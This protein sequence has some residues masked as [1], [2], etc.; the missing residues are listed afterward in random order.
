VCDHRIV[1]ATKP[2]KFWLRVDVRRD[3]EATFTNFKLLPQTKFSYEA[4]VREWF[5][6]AASEATTHVQRM[7]VRGNYQV[8]SLMIYGSARPGAQVT[9]SV[10]TTKIA[11]AVPTQPVVLPDIKSNQKLASEHDNSTPTF[12][13]SQLAAVNAPFAR[14]IAMLPSL[15]QWRYASA[16]NANTLLSRASM[17]QQLRAV[18]SANDAAAHVP[19][20][21]IDVASLLQSLNAS[22]TA[23]RNDNSLQISAF[24]SMI[25][26]LRSADTSDDD[27]ARALAALEARGGEQWDQVCCVVASC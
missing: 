2:T 22:L 25:D 3:K 11:R 19:T 7:I 23:M 17:R 13:N 10:P 9:A 8:L 18:M 4:G 15:T 24:S 1:S 20:Q 5:W 12:I 16:A 26:A 21:A 27:G 6:P 14:V